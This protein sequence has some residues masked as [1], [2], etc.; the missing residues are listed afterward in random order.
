MNERQNIPAN[1]WTCKHWHSGQHAN[2]SEPCG[3]CALEADRDRLA[4]EVERLTAE[5]DAAFAMSKCECGT[6]EA[7]ANLGR[8]HAEVEALRKV[9]TEVRVWFS[10]DTMLGK[11]L[12]EK[13]DAAMKEHPNG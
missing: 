5:R 4:S 12:I 3:Y 2:A 7:C 1:R 9:L 8:L 10:P 6:D 13:V 11:A